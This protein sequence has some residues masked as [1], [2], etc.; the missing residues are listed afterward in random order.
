MN[1][2]FNKRNNSNKEELNISCNTKSHINI[3]NIQMIDPSNNINTSNFTNE[4]YSKNCPD[5]KSSFY[6]YYNMC[7]H[8]E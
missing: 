6:S 4:I 7:R 5:C 8:I 1:E 2:S 3:F